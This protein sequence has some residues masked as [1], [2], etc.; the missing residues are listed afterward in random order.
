V[1]WA[2]TIV[3]AVTAGVTAVVVPAQAASSHQLVSYYYE[4][5]CLSANFSNDVYV[6]PCKAGV[7]YHQWED[8]GL[9]IFNVGTGNCI[10][11]NPNTGI[12]T[13]ARDTCQTNL[14]WH[15][16]TYRATKYNSSGVVTR[17]MFQNLDSGLCL[18]TN[19]ATVFGTT[20][21]ETHG[22]QWWYVS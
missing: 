7:I 20:C 9:E 15:A 18:S 17:T 11:S 19:N 14:T 21:D 1:A 16:W 2:A 6:T 3:V 13:V 4:D 10:S 5:Q 8:D 22:Q 12:Y